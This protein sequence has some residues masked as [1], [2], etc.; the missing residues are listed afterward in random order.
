MTL[1]IR[2]AR[3]VVSDLGGTLDGHGA[4]TQPA[5]QV[6]REIEAAGGRAVACHASVADEAGASYVDG[7]L[8]VEI[9]LAQPGESVR[10]VPISDS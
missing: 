3:V 1:L 4:S 10:R 2:G 9:P 7:V 5:D 8:Q 6:V